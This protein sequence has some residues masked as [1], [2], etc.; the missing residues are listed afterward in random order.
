MR[1]TFRVKLA[2]NENTGFFIFGDSV[3]SSTIANKFEGSRFAKSVDY[4]NTK[5]CAL[6]VDGKQPTDGSDL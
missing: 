3:S 2:L 1:Q 4:T 5:K 6:F